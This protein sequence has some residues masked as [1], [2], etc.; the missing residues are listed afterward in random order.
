MQY[1]LIQFYFFYYYI[2]IILLSDFVFHLCPVPDG[3]RRDHS[4]DQHPNRP[5]QAGRLLGGLHLR[6]RLLGGSR[7][8]FAGC[9]GGTAIGANEGSG[10]T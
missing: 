6:Q 8:V 2:I 5:D 4:R 9:G 3:R 1:P 10:K 7:G